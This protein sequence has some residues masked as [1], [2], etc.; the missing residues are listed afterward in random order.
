MDIVLLHTSWGMGTYF[1][2]K[3]LKIEHFEI[4]LY[5][6]IS[7]ASRYRYCSQAL[8]RNFQRDATINFFKL[9][10]SAYFD[11]NIMQHYYLIFFN[12]L[13]HYCC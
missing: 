3:M 1:P 8:L 12:H 5:S 2:Q 9:Y 10:I 11:K 13:G 4:K 7:N 6:K